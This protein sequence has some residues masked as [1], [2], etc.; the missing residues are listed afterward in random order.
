MSATDRGHRRAGND[1]VGVHRP[2]GRGPSRTRARTTATQQPVRRDIVE[3]R[4][5]AALQLGI[6]LAHEDGSPATATV[7]IWQCDALGRYS[8][9]PPPKDSSVVTAA[10]APAAQ[11]LPDDT[12][13]R[14]SQPTDAAGM[15][16]FRTIYP[17]WYPGRT[18]HIH[19]IVQVGDGAF[20]SQLYFP[21]H[22]N[23]EV[24]ARPPYS[25]AAGSRHDQRHRHDPSHRRHAGRPRHPGCRRRVPRRRVPAAP[26]R[27]VSGPVTAADAA[28]VADSS[29]HPLAACVEVTESRESQVGAFRVRRALPRR[30]RRT[31]GA[32]CFLD[33]MGPAAIDER[34]GL[35]RR[36]AP[37]HRPADRHLAARRRGAPPR[38]ARH[39]AGHR[40]PA[41]ST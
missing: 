4:P 34:H 28:P 26:E 27:V 15:V 25:R 32:W 39:R 17:G 19:L 18:V 3:D 8:G 14:G 2:S 33:H 35:G 13:L 20:T 16:E 41:S 12:F 37:P 24:L 38:L 29:D 9:F 30:G 10:T 21:E 23:D 22:V 1:A 5:G 7:E 31:V 6:R 40:R 36:T 11:Y